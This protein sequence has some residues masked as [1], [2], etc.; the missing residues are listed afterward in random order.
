[1][2]F[3]GNL[4]YLALLFL[5]LGAVTA[6]PASA[7]ACRFEYSEGFQEAVVLPAARNGLGDQLPRWNVAKPDVYIEGGRVKVLVSLLPDPAG[8]FL[9]PP[10][11]VILVDDCG[12]GAVRSGIE[13]W[14]VALGLRPPT[15]AELK[16]SGYLH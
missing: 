11:F 12:A 5:L 7:K 10:Y 16:R 2:R 13:A 14:D 4:P 3:L 9:D 15:P 1:M 6:S 8:D